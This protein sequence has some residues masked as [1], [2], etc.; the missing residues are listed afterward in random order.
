MNLKSLS[1]L[2]T[3]TGGAVVLS[4]QQAR[5][6]SG[7]KVMLN[8]GGLLFCCCLPSQLSRPVG[9]GYGM[10]PRWGAGGTVI[11]SASL[12]QG[13]ALGYGIAGF[14]PAGAHPEG[15]LFYSQGQRP[16]TGYPKQS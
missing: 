9:P 14:Q 11:V 7:R 2:L 10:A 5:Q 12:A 16:W 6:A 4:A 1:A 3:P 15:G 13:V 8:P